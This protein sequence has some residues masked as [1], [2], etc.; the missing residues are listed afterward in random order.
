MTKKDN[1]GELVYFA[2]SK[3]T[4]Y[5]E[6][7][8][9]FLVQ[10][11]KEYKSFDY[12]NGPVLFDKNNNPVYTARDS[13]NDYNDKSRIMIGNK[14]GITYSGNIYE[15]K[16]TPSGK[17][18]YVVSKVKGYNKGEDAVY[19]NFIIVDGVESKHYNSVS[20]VTF[21]DWEVP[22]FTAS[23]KDNKYFI[24]KGDKV[25]SEKYDNIYDYTFM[26]DGSL[27]Y[28]GSNFGNYEK[29]VPDNNFVHIS[30]KEFGPYEF[31]SMADYTSGKYILTDY[32]NNYAFVSGKLINPT[33]Y[34]YKYTVTSNNGKSEEH[35]GID[36]AKLINGKV[37]YISV[38]NINRVN[39]K[40]KYS[41]YIDN[42]L[43][44]DDYESIMDFYYDKSTGTLSF[45][46]GKGNS[47]FLLEYKI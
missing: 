37:V 46:A 41:L 45:V 31:I 2:K 27:A 29:Q 19:E 47:F 23:N 10:G 1:N 32:N 40:N 33:E 20:N 35:D 36:I 5:I 43:T 34:I 4:F 12:V 17:L 38:D 25:I 7:G 44:A 3:G 8:N 30:G 18:V 21:T 16:I 24:V 42:K 26:K 28:I 39:Y 13:A 15:Y 14:E 11:N 9:A 6:C 22:V